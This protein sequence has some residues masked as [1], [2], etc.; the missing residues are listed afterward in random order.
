MDS[1]LYYNTPVFNDG[2]S[3]CPVCDGL[4]KVAVP[5]WNNDDECYDVDTEKCSA[6][7]GEGYA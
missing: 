7:K 2:E 5:I 1:E 3:I 4:G 6:C